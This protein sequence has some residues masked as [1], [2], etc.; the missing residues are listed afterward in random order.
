MSGVGGFIDAVNSGYER[1]HLAFEDQFWGTKMG[2]A[3]PKFSTAE[4]TKTKKEMEDFL[5]DASRLEETRKWLAGGEAGAEQTKTLKMFERT[6][7]CYIMESEE[8]KKLRGDATQLEGTLGEARNKLTLG[9]TLPDGFKELSSVGLRNRMRTDPDESIRK[10]CYEALVSIGPFVCKNGLLEIVKIRNQMAK[11]LGYVDFYDYKVS[12]SEGFNKEKLFQILD[13]LEKGT[14]DLQIQARKRLAQEK[15]EDV[16]KPWNTG[17][18]MAGNITKKLDPYFPFEKA[19]EMWARSYAALG[20]NYKSATMNLDL[21][22][23]KG[24]YSNGFCHWPQPAWTRADG[25]WQPSTANFTSLAD[26]SAAGSG[27]TALTTLM[28][29]AGHA[30]HFANVSQPSPL[31]SQERAPTSVAYAENQSMFLDSLCDDAAWRGRYAR[32]REGEVVPW[33]LLEEDI[34]ARQPYA[35]FALRLMMSVPY[36]EKALYELPEDQ[37]TAERVQQLANEVEERI[38]GG[39]SGRP[40]LSVPHIL[41]DE[42]SCYYHG[43]VLAEMSVHQTRAYFLE[44]HGNIVDNPIVGPTLT[45]KYWKPGNSAMFLDLVEGLTGKPL[46]GESW[47]KEL[48]QPLE[49]AVA[50][51]K[52]EYEAAVKAGMAVTGEL[53]LGMRVR[54]VDGSE[55]IADTKEEGTF[56]K[57]TE[58]FERFVRQRIA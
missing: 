41:D 8:A 52:A 39:L 2:L 54:L 51:E 14:R 34:R 26:P 18:M 49:E 57:A 44:K 45:E 23:R 15:G 58:K 20:I 22:D 5:A 48:Q 11:K 50:H 31:F 28:H 13:T 16:L 35:V 1:V 19:V 38:Q 53:D 6:F 24:K 30:A 47:V 40:L 43:Y 17:Y 55:V 9:I 46:T 25:A 4:L 21:L 27:L 33:S 12:Q 10:S 32:N 3:D 7:G 56:L 37:I 36:F 42:S 29:E